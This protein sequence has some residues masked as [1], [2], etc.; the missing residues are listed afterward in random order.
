MHTFFLV[1]SDAST[2]LVVGLA[3]FWFHWDDS[4]D[5][6]LIIKF[7]ALHESQNGKQNNSISLDDS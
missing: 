7:D 6:R 5:Y 1:S 3:L 2:L 4:Y